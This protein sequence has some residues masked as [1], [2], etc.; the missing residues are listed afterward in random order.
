M[1]SMTEGIQVVDLTSSFNSLYPYNF[2]SSHRPHPHTPL[3]HPPRPAANPP[4]SPPKNQVLPP[5]LVRRTLLLSRMR[6]QQRRRLQR[7]CPDLA[8]GCRWPNY[9]WCGAPFCY[10]EYVP[11]NTDVEVAALRGAGGG[12]DE[13]LS[14]WMVR[15]AVLLSRVWP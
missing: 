15:C 1:G 10:P 11:L 3:H 12:E 7:P 13:A 9:G 2:S 14:S 6:P 8:R 4:P 5:R